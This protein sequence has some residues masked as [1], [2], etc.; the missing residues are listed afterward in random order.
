MTTSENSQKH[1]GYVSAI[2]LAAMSQAE[3]EDYMDFL[4]ENSL[5]TGPEWDRL[6][7]VWEE[8]SL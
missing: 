1:R 3:R 5:D 4:S 7:A 2:K 8:L 6:Y